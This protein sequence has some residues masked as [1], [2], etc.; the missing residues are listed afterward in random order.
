MGTK[1]G[2]FS[3]PVLQAADILVHGYHHPPERSVDIAERPSATHV[4]VGADQ[5][6]H[7]EFTRECA[8]AFNHQYGQVLTRPATMTSMLLSTGH[9][10]I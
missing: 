1:L 8:G 3:Y 2:L 4:P 9:E 5:E 6:Q 10:L 7:L